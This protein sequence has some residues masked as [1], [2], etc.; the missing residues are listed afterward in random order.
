M[1]IIFGKGSFQG[2]ISG[3]DEI[4]TASATHLQRAGHT[5]SVLLLY[6]PALTDQYY[7]RLRDAGVS[8][9]SVA[10]SGVNGSISV[11]RKLAR[12]L[13]ESFPASQGVVRRRS[14]EVSS[15]IAFRYYDQCRLYFEHTRAD[16][17]HVITPDWGGM[18]MIRAAHDAA[19]PVLYQEVGTPFHPPGF[20]TYYQ[21]F[22]SVL[23]L[24]AEVAAL[25][26]QL[27]TECR[28]KLP[29]VNVSV[30]PILIDDKFDREAASAHRRAERHVTFGF[31]ARLEHLKGPLVL[32]D[33]FAKARR[34]L[35]ESKLE[36]AGSGS[37]K[38]RLLARAKAHG[39]SGLCEFPG[40]Y[41]TVEE[42]GGFMQSLDVFVLPS[43]TEGTPNGI[44]EAMAYGLPVISTTVGGI[45]DLVSDE[46]G[47]LVAPDDVE[48]LA[49]AMIRLAQD[50]HLR[51]RMGRAARKQYEKLF[52]PHLTLPLMLDTYRRITNGNGHH[53]AHVPPNGNG[54]LHPWANINL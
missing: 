6:P 17:V 31:A 50:P 26:P 20:E 8:V 19:I 41:T 16:L 25:S 23:P 14:Q 5:V 10:S 21:R 40:V 2:P 35:P 48:A 36:I 46:T 30:L 39:I 53:P 12:G 18:V 9:S 51:E 37:L 54:L 28:E 29:A 3:A 13:L 43:L 15:R 7:L 42:K 44:I 32:I 1:R 22:T 49:Q 27:A 45:P 24:C 34:T 38:R 47:I 33:A 11:G 52:S 4:L